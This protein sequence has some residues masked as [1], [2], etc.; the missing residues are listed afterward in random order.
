[1]TKKQRI[2]QLEKEVQELKN[3]LQFLD[4]MS[5]P[6]DIPAPPNDNY[7]YD[8]DPWEVRKRNRKI[9]FYH[10]IWYHPYEGFHYDYR[11]R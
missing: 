2:E 1:M 5:K 6:A 4:I 7:K 10:P 8:L 3:K 11:T 9:T